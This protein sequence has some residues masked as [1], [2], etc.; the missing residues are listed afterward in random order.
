MKFRAFDLV[1]RSSLS[2][3]IL[4]FENYHIWTT[5]RYHPNAAVEQEMNITTR[6]SVLDLLYGPSLN[7]NIPLFTNNRIFID[8]AVS[9]E[10][11]S[12]SR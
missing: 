9:P 3:K 1:Y 11:R 4:L 8:H 12:L 10:L 2:T 5:G 6:F 7:A